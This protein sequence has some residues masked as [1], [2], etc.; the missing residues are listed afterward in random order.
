[1]RSDFGHGIEKPHININYYK[2]TDSKNLKIN[3]KSID[4]IPQSMQFENYD[5][6]GLDQ[7]INLVLWQ[8]EKINPH[9]GLKYWLLTSFF[10]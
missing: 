5:Q 10:Q 2:E 6:G 7:M 9:I 1:M 3:D 4:Y 8:A